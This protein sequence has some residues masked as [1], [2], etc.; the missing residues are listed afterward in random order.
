[1]RVRG[2]GFGF[3]SWGLGFRVPGS[4]FELGGVCIGCRETAYIHLFLVVIHLFLVVRDKFMSGQGMASR[5]W[6]G[7]ITPT[8]LNPAQA[9]RAGVWERLW[10][11]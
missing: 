2:S 4:R 9:P 1:L 5:A 11:G 6:E 10:G 7:F 3:K 8:A